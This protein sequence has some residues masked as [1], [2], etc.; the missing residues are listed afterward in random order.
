MRLAGAG[1]ATRSRAAAR[2]GRPAERRAAGERRPGLAGFAR[3]GRLAMAAATTTLLVAASSSAAGASPLRWDHTTATTPTLVTGARSKAV[4][5]TSLVTMPLPAPPPA[6]LPDSCLKGDWPSQVSGAPAVFLLANGAYLWYDPDGGWALR[7]TH[8]GLRDHA[9][10]SGYLTTQS[11]ELT[12]VAAM[13]AVAANAGP[14]GDDIIYE[15]AD[16]HTVFFRFVGFGLLDGLNFATQCVRGF[17][18][19]IHIGLRALPHGAVHLGSSGASPA[20]NPFRVTRQQAGPP[21][22][23]KSPKAR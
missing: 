12:D 3:A 1:A 22:T 13:A 21:G 17:A 7:V 2:L 15:T 11:G 6:A 10:F 20:S 14:A 16:K 18:V 8:W 4:N 9:V 19:S 23:P 5:G